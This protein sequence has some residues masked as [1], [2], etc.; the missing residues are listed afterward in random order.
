MMQAVWLCS[1]YTT[2]TLDS[3]VCT[4]GFEL[5]VLLKM[6]KFGNHIS[7]YRLQSLIPVH[8][9]GSSGRSR[10]E[11]WGPGQGYD[12]LARCLAHFHCK[13][14]IF[15]S[16]DRSSASSNDAATPVLPSLANLSAW[17]VQRHLTRLLNL[18]LPFQSHPILILVKPLL[19]C[20]TVPDFK[21][22]SYLP[23]DSTK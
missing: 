10:R 4:L 11:L 1:Q 9:F 20:I 12:Q 22:G 14:H 6:V 19:Y 5:L 21:V 3:R 2:S 13:P 17:A 7:L 16:W 18:L 23:W 15:P 8:S